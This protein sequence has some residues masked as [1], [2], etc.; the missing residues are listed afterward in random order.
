M[1]DLDNHTGADYPQSDTTG[2]LQKRVQSAQDDS[3]IVNNYK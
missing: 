2:D 1:D 3:P